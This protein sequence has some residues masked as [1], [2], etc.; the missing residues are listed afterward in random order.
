MYDG[1]WPEGPT[2][3]SLSWLEHRIHNPEVGSSSLPSDIFL[4]LL[5]GF[6]HS[7]LGLIET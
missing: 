5:K 1:D 7:L 4:K 2:S 6:Q 3:E